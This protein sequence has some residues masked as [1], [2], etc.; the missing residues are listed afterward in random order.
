MKKTT[1]PSKVMSI[2]KKFEK[3]F[4]TLLP[5]PFTI[6]VLLTFF[7]FVLALWITDPKSNQIHIVELLLYWEKGIWNSPLLVFAMQMMLMLVNLKQMKS[8]ENS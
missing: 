7:T 1:Y 4:K 6:A 3:I 8:E 2:T 5:A